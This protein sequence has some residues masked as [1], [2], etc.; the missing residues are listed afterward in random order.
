M[1]PQKNKYRKR[2]NKHRVRTPRVEPNYLT[3]QHGSRDYL[4]MG[5]GFAPVSPNDI[6]WIDSD[7]PLTAEQIKATCHVIG[8]IPK[9]ALLTGDYSQA[10]M[11][12]DEFRKAGC[13][14]FEK[15]ELVFDGYEQDTR[16]LFKIPE[17]RA[18]I[19][20]AYTLYPEMLLYFDKEFVDYIL[21]C[22]LDINCTI[23]KQGVVYSVSPSQ[24][25]GARLKKIQDACMQYKDSVCDNHCH[26]NEE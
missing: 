11:Q 20:Q 21:Y 13:F 24:A 17:I 16:P 10:F 3:F 19:R 14:S 1:R 23:E 15:L 25:N 7:T 6:S 9:Q 12:F 22:L 4:E 2:S 26:F 18:F 8:Y 5:N